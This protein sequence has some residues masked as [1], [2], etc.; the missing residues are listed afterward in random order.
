ML[1]RGAVLHPRMPPRPHTLDKA[2]AKLS[3][4]LAA[5]VVLTTSSGWPNVVTSNMFKPAPS[6]RLL[7][8]TGFFSGFRAEV[9]GGARVADIVCFMSR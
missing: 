2:P 8:L 4:L 1:V 7:N 9:E 5:I 3:V 6:S